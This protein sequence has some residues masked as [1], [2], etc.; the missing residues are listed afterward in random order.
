MEGRMRVPVVK[1]REGASS[2]G[3]GARGA[4]PG[5][6]TRP[7]AQRHEEQEW[8]PRGFVGAASDPWFQLRTCLTVVGWSPTSG[9]VLRAESA[10]DSPCLSARAGILSN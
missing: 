9:S 5:P 7:A 6:L 8:G 1:R 2:P 10:S 4:A 3:R